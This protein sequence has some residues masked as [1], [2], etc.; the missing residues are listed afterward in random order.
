[1]ITTDE[2]SYSHSITVGIQGVPVDGTID[3]GADTITIGDDVFYKVV[4]VAR[5][6]K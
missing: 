5:L 6:R 4:T 1:M 3:T 2:G